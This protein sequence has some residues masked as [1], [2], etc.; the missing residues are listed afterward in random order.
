MKKIF[1][2]VCAVL[3]SAGAQAGMDNV[4]VSFSTPGPDKYADGTIVADG[5]CYALVWTPTNETFVG[6]AAD[7][8]ALGKSKVAIAAPVA[9]GGRCPNILF[10]IDE[11]YA[12]ANYDGGTWGV[13]LLDTRRFALDVNGQIQLDAKG[14]RVIESV[15]DKALVNGYG[16]ISMLQDGDKIVTCAADPVSAATTSASPTGA[17]PT[18][19][20]IRIADGNVYVTVKNASSS[21]LYSLASGTAP[22]SIAADEAASAAYGPADAADEIILVTPQKAATGFF[23]V[24]RK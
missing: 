3:L 6:I 9:K 7:G 18:I 21:V 4:L 13:C 22:D 1:S 14:N 17:Q 10:Q 2:I 20:A 12:K 16:A 23:K 24:N 19:S 15:G 5:E 11:K 8:A